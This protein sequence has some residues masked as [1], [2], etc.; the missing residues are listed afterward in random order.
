MVSAALWIRFLLLLAEGDVAEKLGAVEVG[1]LGGDGEQRQEVGHR[2]AVATLIG[3]AAHVEA[4][5]VR[6][7]NWYLSSAIRAYRG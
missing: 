1:P 4:S 5:E 7:C 3:V 2:Q 6:W